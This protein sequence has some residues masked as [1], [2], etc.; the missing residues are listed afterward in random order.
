[1]RGKKALRHRIGITEQGESTE[2]RNVFH[3]LGR[4]EIIP[5]LM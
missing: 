4:S 1:M 3:D 2:L 5:Y